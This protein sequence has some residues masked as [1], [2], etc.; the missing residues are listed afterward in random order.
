LNLFEFSLIALSGL[1]GYAFAKKGK[2][3]DS[4]ANTM[5]NSGDSGSNDNPTAAS[6]SDSDV[7]QVGLRTLLQI[8]WA[9]SLR[10]T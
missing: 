10:K 3:G 8:P 4:T 9:V 2:G 7:T 6:S 5:T 1:A